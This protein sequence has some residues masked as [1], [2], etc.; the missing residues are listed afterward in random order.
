M[1][2]DLGTAHAGTLGQRLRYIGGVHAAI[3]WKVK[4]R[5]D[6]RY[7][8]KWPHGLDLRQRNLVT[9]HLETPRQRASAAHLEGLIGGHRELNRSTIDNPRGLTGL[10]FELAIKILRVLSELGLRF[11]VAEGG[12]QA[13]RM[14]S[15][16]ASQLFA[17][18]QHHVLPAKFGQ[19][20]GER[21]P[22][23]TP[24][25]DDDARTAGKRFR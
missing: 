14:P 22:D 19:V 6:I 16:A 1:F 13:R 2:E 7:L 18:E 21:T 23:H 11:G 20:V 12:Q 9:L 15:R 25:D 8:R 17:L 3:I 24:A 5:N 4:R 10:G